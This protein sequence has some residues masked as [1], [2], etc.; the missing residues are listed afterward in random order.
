[1]L[2]KDVNASMRR[3]RYQLKL[4]YNKA[5]GLL[6]YVRND[7]PSITRLNTA[8]S[9]INVAASSLLGFHFGIKHFYTDDW[10]AY[11]RKL[12][13]SQHTISKTNTQ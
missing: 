8:E 12:P 10:G 4:I 6:R 9:S 1:M 11:Q 2:K 3:S 7:D 5:T 13:G